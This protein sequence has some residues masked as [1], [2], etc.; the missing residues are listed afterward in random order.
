MADMKQIF[1]YPSNSGTDWIDPLY[2]GNSTSGLTRRVDE[3]LAGSYKSWSNLDPVSDLA[4][5]NSEAMQNLSKFINYFED[6]KLIENLTFYDYWINPMVVAHRGI[7]A[8]DAPIT[9]ADTLQPATI[10]TA[11]PHEFLDGML[12]EIENFD[13]TWGTLYNSGT[14]YCKKVSSTEI[15]ASF[16]EALTDLVGYVPLVTANITG[17]DL[18]YEHG[19][20]PG[21]IEIDLTN[22][23]IVPTSGA[24]IIFNSIGSQGAS[25]VG[26]T[27]YLLAKGPSYPNVYLIFEDQLLTN[28][29]TLNDIAP[30]PST[31]ACSINNGTNPATITAPS[32]LSAD[33]RKV[34]VNTPEQWVDGVYRWNSDQIYYLKTTGTSTVYEVYTDAAY[35]QPVNFDPAPWNPAAGEPAGVNKIYGLLQPAMSNTSNVAIE[36]KDTHQIFDGDPLT[37]D[38]IPS[39]EYLNAASTLG[40]N[41]YY[42]KDTGN[43]AIETG[44]KSYDLYE[45]SGLTNP[46]NIS[47]LTNLGTH[48]VD[49]EIEGPQRFPAGPVS[50]LQWTSVD[51]TPATANDYWVGD[52]C[53][54]TIVIDNNPDFNITAG[55]TLTWEA[56]SE[57]KAYIPTLTTSNL[58][59]IPEAGVIPNAP[60][61]TQYWKSPKIWV[62]TSVYDR[63]VKTPYSSSVD[64]PVVNLQSVTKNGVG[65]AAGGNLPLFLRYIGQ[66]DGGTQYCCILENFNSAGPFFAPSSAAELNVVNDLTGTWELGSSPGKITFPSE[67]GTMDLQMYVRNDLSFLSGNAFPDSPASFLNYPA[68]GDHITLE[69]T[70]TTG[71]FEYTAKTLGTSPGDPIVDVDLSWHASPGGIP[72][73][74]IR[75]YDWG[76]VFTDSDCT[77][78]LDMNQVLNGSTNTWPSGSEAEVFYFTNGVNG[79][80]PA[81]AKFIIESSTFFKNDGSQSGAVS[82]KIYIKHLTGITYQLYKD[83]ALTV[84]ITD[85]DAKTSTTANGIAPNTYP[86]W[87]NQLGFMNTEDY[88]ILNPGTTDF[89]DIGAANNNQG[90]VFTATYP[91]T[92]PYLYG[93]GTGTAEESTYY[94]QYLESSPAVAATIVTSYNETYNLQQSSGSTYK[95]YDNQGV[96]IA[97]DMSFEIRSGSDTTTLLGTITDLDI[98]VKYHCGSDGV[99]YTDSSK[100]TAVISTDFGAINQDFTGLSYTSNF[101]GT[102]YQYHTTVRIYEQLSTGLTFAPLNLGDV[103]L[104]RYPWEMDKMTHRPWIFGDLY[105]YTNQPNRVLVDDNTDFSS[106]Y[107]NGGNITVGFQN[108]IDSTT[109]T[110]S[111]SAT[112]PNPYTIRSQEII[113]PGN[114]TYSYQ[115][116]SNVT[117]YDADVDYTKWWEPGETTESYLTDHSGQISH[118]I[119]VTVNGSGKLQTLVPPTFQLGRYAESSDMLLELK[120]PANQYTPPTPT[121]AEL[122]DVWDTDDEWASDGVASGLKQWPDHVTP[123]SAVINYNSPTIAN[124]SQSGIKY[125]RSVGHTKWRLEVDYPPMSAEDFKKFHAIAQAAHGQSTPFYFNLKNKDNVSILWKDFYDQS[126]TTTTPLFKDAI[127]PGNTLALFEGFSSNESNVFMQGEVFI[128]GENENGNLHTS[129]SGTSSNI[130]GEA[131]IRTPWPFRTAVSAG[132]KIYKNPAH[133]VVT[134]ASDNF[135]YQVDVNNYYYVSVAFDLD[136]WK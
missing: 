94:G 60:F 86:A 98:G 130:F 127:T 66:N 33:L 96:V 112:E 41:T 67:L 135:E 55:D 122:E 83:E 70:S 73:K 61:D 131:K 1:T 79:Q 3:L 110:V 25:L 100:T 64:G 4:T 84:P 48:T 126:N 22:S 118:D 54:K 92:A 49:I 21:Q 82:R 68:A 57:G 124:S 136:S 97:Q 95:V 133:A 76:L 8:N 43:T 27:Y 17:D 88:T 114:E 117:Q 14:F 121:Q 115:D 13:G 128:D 119:T 72:N 12:I 107:T 45:D 134:L 35:T 56:L 15:Q 132:E 104:V 90:T 19:L 91:G 53:T 102:Q 80:T 2:I 16:N 11:A 116:S 78:K 24:Y 74:K 46:L 30:L 38:T 111:L 101:R 44:F 106:I 34:Y 51:N 6:N 39:S 69:R 93:T 99:L 62:D 28:P 47:D 20:A 5:T 32:G 36:I 31:T 9:S 109:G 37:F 10:T 105:Q 129:L 81:R 77:V 26:N 85:A 23:G 113:L 63:L 103:T 65:L 59:S 7:V 123:Q 42:L 120:S 108:L 75:D 125:T 29:L 52:Y 18:T 71:V 87:D 40:G 58:L 89:T 50:P